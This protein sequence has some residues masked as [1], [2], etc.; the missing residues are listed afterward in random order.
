MRVNSPR[1]FVLAILLIISVEAIPTQSLQSSDPES[2]RAFVRNVIQTETAFFNNRQRYVYRQERP[3]K[4]T[5]LSYDVVETDKLTIERLTCVNGQPLSDE[6]DASEMARLDRLEKDPQFQA[7]LIRDQEAENN[8]RL[9]MLRA[10]PDAFI[11]TVDSD[12]STTPLI[13]IDFRPDPKYRPSS[14]EAQAYRGMQGSLWIDQQHGRLIRVLG[15]LTKGVSFGWG[16]L[17]HLNR[18]GTFALEQANVYGDDWTVT[19]MELHF[20]GSILFFKPLHIEYAE[21]SFDFRP[22]ASDISLTDAIAL[23]RTSRNETTGLQ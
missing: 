9:R 14:K 13:K 7:K 2:T 3:H 23:L 11:F 15:K 1:L 6:Q 21:H 19:K 16:I 8:R 22:I 12:H 20:T 5:L 10:L 17:G 18:G 4:A